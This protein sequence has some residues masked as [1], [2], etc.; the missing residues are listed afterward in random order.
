MALD[1]IPVEL[2]LNIADELPV[3]DISAL[4]RSCRLFHH[5]IHDYLYRR[6][7]EDRWALFWACIHNKEQTARRAIANGT[8]PH[9]PASHFLM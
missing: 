8:D 1:N 3:E 7:A 5:A 2:L 6:D 4:E 9:E